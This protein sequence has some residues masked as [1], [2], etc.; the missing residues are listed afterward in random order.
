[1]LLLR[2]VHECNLIESEMTGIQVTLILL[3][4]FAFDGTFAIHIDGM[5]VQIERSQNDTN[6]FKIEWDSFQNYSMH[7]IL[8][9]NSLSLQVQT[10]KWWTISRGDF[11]FSRKCIH[12]LQCEWNNLWNFPNGRRNQE[13][14]VLFY[15]CASRLFCIKCFCVVLWI[16]KYFFCITVERLERKTIYTDDNRTF[17][18]DLKRQSISVSNYLTK[19]VQ[20]LKI[21]HHKQVILQFKLQV[22]YK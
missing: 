6:E 3:S 10:R 17:E 5:D 14:F 20:L 21:C 12:I 8:F 11:A 1:M 13:Q 7:N 9:R 19:W 2:S 18:F 22:R 15:V 4:F 16:V